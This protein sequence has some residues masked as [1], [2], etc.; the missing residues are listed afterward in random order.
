MKNSIIYTD[1]NSAIHYI[2]NFNRKKYKHIIFK[3][4]SIILNNNPLQWIPAHKNMKGNEVADLEQKH[5]TI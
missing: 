5:L 2:Q 3:N 4:Q 1:F